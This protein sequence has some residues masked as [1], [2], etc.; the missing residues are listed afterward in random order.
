M[1]HMCSNNV[2]GHNNGRAVVLMRGT[3]YANHNCKPNVVTTT[4]RD[5]CFLHALRPIEPGEELFLCYTPEDEDP[6]VM[7]ECIA[8]KYWFLCQCD[9]CKPCES[10]W[11]RCQG[12]LARRPPQPHEIVRYELRAALK[13]LSH[14]KYVLSV[15]K[16]QADDATAE[17]DAAIDEAEADEPDIEDSKSGATAQQH[18]KI[19]RLSKVADEAME[20]QRDGEERLAKAQ[21]DADRAIA[22]GK[23][24]EAEYRADLA[25]KPGGV[26]PA[27]WCSD[28]C[29]ERQ[30]SCFPCKSSAPPV[31]YDNPEDAKPLPAQEY[32]YGLT[33]GPMPTGAGAGGK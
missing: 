2:M 23:Q 17:A 10:D 12:C 31:S 29:Q 16:K 7:N 1:H 24:L 33:T 20:I 11:V 25:T 15:A 22:N 4:D 19:N 3:S 8:E 18:Q 27:W 21:A 9:R 14:A 6:G 28:R 13:A 32:K 5:L 30:T 26:E